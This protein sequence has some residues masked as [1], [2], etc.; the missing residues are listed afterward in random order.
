MSDE[1]RQHPT[2][3]A[4]G[5]L[6]AGSKGEHPQIPIEWGDSGCLVFILRSSSDHGLAMRMYL[7]DP[8]GNGLALDYDR[9]R[10]PVAA[11][12]SRQKP[13]PAAR[14]IRKRLATGNLPRREEPELNV[15]NLIALFW[16]HAE[17]YYQRNGKPTGEITNIRYRIRPRAIIG[18]RRN[19]RTSRQ[20]KAA[21]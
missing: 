19:S 3:F 2:H 16:V 8:D 18:A 6:A 11:Y 10:S 15:N 17:S 9:P 12:G 1:L 7:R 21:T 4:A 20:R 5:G 14:L 13:S